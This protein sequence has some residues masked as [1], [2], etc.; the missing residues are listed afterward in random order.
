MRIKSGGHV[1]F[2]ID[3]IGL[4]VMGLAKGDFTPVWA[5]V[6]KGLPAHQLLAYLCAIISLAGGIGLLWR[7]TAAPAAASF[8]SRCCFGYSS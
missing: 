5:P 3:F 2:A 7:R 6:P 1:A 4:G 8:S